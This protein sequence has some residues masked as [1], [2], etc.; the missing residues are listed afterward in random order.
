MDVQS[1]SPARRFPI[2]LE[3]FLALALLGWF[4]ASV[5]AFARSASA[6]FDEPLH[7]SAGYS[8]LRWDDYR[9]NPEHPPLIKKLAALPWLFADAWPHELSLRDTDLKPAAQWDTDRLLRRVWAT[10]LRRSG[11]EATFGEGLLYG[12]RPEILARFPQAENPMHLPTQSVF[13]R[14][15]FLNDTST[16]LFQARLALLPLGLV[17]A[18]LVWCWARELFGA[19]GGLVS[20]ALFCGDPNFA[21]HC[22]LVTTDAGI[23]LCIFATIF[24]L[25]RVLHHASWT[26]LLGLF[27][28]FGLAFTVKFSAVLLVP[29]FGL[30]AGGWIIARQIESGSGRTAFWRSVWLFGFASL[31]AWGIVWAAYSFRFTAAADVKQAAADEV[32]TGVPVVDGREP[33]HFPTVTGTVA[34]FFRTHKLL[35]EAFIC[36]VASTKGSTGARTAYLWGEHTNGGCWSYFG[37]TFLLKT[38]LVSLALMLVGA[39]SVLQRHGEGRMLGWFIFASAGFYFVVAVAMRFNI[40]HRHLLPVYPFLFVLAGGAGL[41]I[42]TWSAGRRWLFGTMTLGLILI[43]SRVVFFP[44][45]AMAERTSSPWQLVSPHPL[46]YFN[47]LAGGP[48]NG[49]LALVDSNLDWGQDLNTLHDWLA[50]HKITQPVA[51]CYFGLADPR[52]HGIA[53]DNLPGG[54]DLEPTTDFAAVQ[55]G[56]LVVVSA[57][58]RVGAYLAESQRGQLQ[59]L[60]AHSTLLDCVGYSIFVYRYEGPD[61]TP[62]N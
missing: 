5:V 48:A 18:L 16:L 52:A 4:V 19:V 44:Q 34:N 62:K 27:L 20:L 49:S 32:R 31:T 24:F 2:I 28:S 1:P 50:A 11:A 39:W 35:P 9:L 14:T 47:E 21:A 10:G 58:K 61:T 41:A 7:L 45:A 15:D 33:G 37:W 29:M 36:G 42:Q 57:T 6:V 22:G 40:G 43:S 38:P 17:L 54:F 56:Q 55:P 3:F 12:V 59:N 46:A 13:T 26:N 51:L 53:H 60:L 8:Y 25:W 23:S 30:A